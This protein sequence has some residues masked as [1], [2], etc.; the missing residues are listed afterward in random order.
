MYFNN[1]D[2]KKKIITKQTGQTSQIKHY[3]DLRL[4]GGIQ[5]CRYR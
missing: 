1:G 2:N 4:M 3:N 5:Q